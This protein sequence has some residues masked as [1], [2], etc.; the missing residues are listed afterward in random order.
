MSSEASQAK[1][2]ELTEPSCP[3][4]PWIASR[5]TAQSSAARQ[6]GPILSMVQVRA[7]APV[8]G[9]R[10]KVGRNPV[11]PQRVQ[12]DEIDPSVSVPIAKATQPAAVAEAEPADDP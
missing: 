1:G 3:S 8:R 5:T 4:G 7:M 12:G 6:I 11:V 2:T 10:P 9:T